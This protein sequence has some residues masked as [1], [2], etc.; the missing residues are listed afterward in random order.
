MELNNRK[1]KK[2]WW[3]GAW[4]KGN[5]YKNQESIKKR[6][7]NDDFTRVAE[8]SNTDREGFAW[9]LEEPNPVEID[10]FSVGCPPSETIG[11][12]GGAWEIVPVVLALLISWFSGPWTIEWLEDSWLG[13]QASQLEVTRTVALEVFASI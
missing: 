6:T 5:Y 4:S 1:H 7:V 9:T 11:V 13:V 2:R 10:K 3:L 8:P 12:E